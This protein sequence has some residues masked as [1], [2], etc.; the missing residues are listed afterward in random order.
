MRKSILTSFAI[1]IFFSQSFS[2]D[3]GIRFVDNLSWSQVKAKAKKENKYI[4][5]D[6]Y[7]TWCGPCKMMDAQVYSTQ[8]IGK[9]LN[10]K[11]ISVKVQ[12][13]QSKNDND[14]IKSWYAD[15]K[16]IN[17]EYKIEALPSFLFFSP[18]GKL[19]YRNIGYQDTAGF[20]RLTQLALT[21]PMKKLNQQLAIYRK[22]K[23]DS[24]FLNNLT[25]MADSLNDKANASLVASEYIKGLRNPYSK[26]NLE[27]IQR[28]T[29]KSTDPGF[30]LF[31]RNAKKV[32]AVLGANSAEQTTRGIIGK[33]ELAPFANGTNIT[34]DWNKLSAA[35]KAKYGDIGEEK[36]NGA[37][38]IYSLDKKDWISFGKY[39]A[40]YYKQAFARSEYHINNLTWPI[41]EHASDTQVLSVAIQTIKYSIDHF[42]KTNYQAYDTYANLLYKIGKKEEALE[43]ERKAAAALPDDKGIAEALDKMQKDEPTWPVNN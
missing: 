37:Q 28:F 34:P 29:R 26:K 17:E 18:E 22:G 16:T 1:L 32:N 11:F 12:Q 10:D 35:V 3:K 21:N 20:M 43:W 19:V 8:T 2:Q 41:F 9:L 40:L 7:A 6:I 39:Y 14:Q 33:E 42:D 38:M 27:F 31:L 23:K 36:I 13:D 24:A 5:L 25:L 15:A 4:F 30:I